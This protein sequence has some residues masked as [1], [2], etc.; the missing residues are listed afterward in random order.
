MSY[1]RVQRLLEGYFTGGTCDRKRA[2]SAMLSKLLIISLS[3]HMT[4]CGF[5]STED[6]LKQYEPNVMDYEL[7]N[8]L[9]INDDEMRALRFYESL[10]KNDMIQDPQGME[11]TGESKRDA[12]SCVTKKGTKCVFPFVNGGNT[13]ASCT[14]DGYHTL[15]CSTSNKNDGTYRTWGECDQTKCKNDICDISGLPPAYQKT[16]APACGKHSLCYACGQKQG[17]TQRTCDDKLQDD[18]NRS[19]ARFGYWTKRTCWMFRRI[20]TEKAR[21]RGSKKYLKKSSQFC[22]KS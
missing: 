1:P 20:V 7:T 12:T 9:V 4:V 10:M 6:E 8:P 15:W 18:L 13:Y 19:C 5:I 14:S 21:S 22:T 17:W 2:V 3:I 11:D 16:F